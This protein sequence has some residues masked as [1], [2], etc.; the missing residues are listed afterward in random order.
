MH[1][2]IISVSNGLKNDFQFHVQL[3]LLMIV[4]LTFCQS[5]VH[6][7][8]L[9]FLRYIKHYKQYK[10]L[11]YHNKEHVND[12]FAYRCH[13][14]FVTGIQLRNVTSPIKTSTCQKITP[15]PSL[16]LTRARLI[17]RRWSSLLSGRW[18]LMWPLTLI[19][20][21]M[22]GQL[23]HVAVNFVRTTQQ[24]QFVASVVLTEKVFRSQV[25]LVNLP[26][27]FKPVPF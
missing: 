19:T 17:P 23:H 1:E 5:F 16:S 3:L 18:W 22:E 4:R 14:F 11:Q 7:L 25:L 21:M 20:Q 9:S 8:V 10:Q 27:M 2:L 12:L 6:Q 15:P 13:V 26:G 24:K